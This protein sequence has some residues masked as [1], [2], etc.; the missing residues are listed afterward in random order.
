[1]ARLL[2]NPN[3]NTL[4]AFVQQAFLARTAI[5]GAKPSKHRG[6]PDEETGHDAA[7]KYRLRHPPTADRASSIRK[8]QRAARI[9]SGERKLDFGTLSRRERRIVRKQMKSVRYPDV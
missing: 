9:E 2:A 4:L 3:V 5:P 6:L 7:V 8:I 1:M